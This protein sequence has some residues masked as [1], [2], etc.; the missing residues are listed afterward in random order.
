MISINAVAA[1]YTHISYLVVKLTQLLQ[2]NVCKLDVQKEWVDNMMGTR[3]EGTG[4]CT[5]VTYYGP[6]GLVWQCNFFYTPVPAKMAITSLVYNLPIIPQSVHKDNLKS[7]QIII[8]HFQHATV[9][10]MLLAS[11]RPLAIQLKY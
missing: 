10:I 1:L 7:K 5:S 8:L 6:D 9:Y 4:L 2:L 11:T 3:F